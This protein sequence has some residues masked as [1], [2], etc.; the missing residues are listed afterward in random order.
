MHTLPQLPYDYTALEPHIDTATMELHHTKHHQTYVDKLN[1]ALENNPELAT[2]P[3][4]DLLKMIDEVP[5]KIR[6]AVVNH[7]GGHTN[8][9]HFWITLTPKA[10]KEPRGNLSSALKLLLA[11]LTPSNPASPTPPPPILAPAGPGSSSIRKK[12]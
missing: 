5:E 3:V 4:E 10:D 9:S 12:S 1:A 2:K 8:H 11:P 7:G 6:Q